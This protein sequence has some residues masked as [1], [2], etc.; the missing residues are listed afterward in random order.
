MKLAFENA[1]GNCF[2]LTDEILN[3][4]FKA[5]RESPRKR[6]ILPLHRTQDSPVQR[7]LNFF[8]PDT[9]VQPHVHPQPGQIETV[10]VLSGS[11][12]FVLFEADGK[13]RK[14]QQL[15][16]GGLGPIDIEPGVWHGMVCLT[17]DT[18]ILEIKK[19]PYDAATDKVFATWAPTENSS[20]APAYLRELEK[21][22]AE[23][24]TGS[25]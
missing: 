21:L 10:H 13:I 23:D 6:I 5:S 16:A 19:G 25:V 7:M 14:T 8:Q 1:S 3:Q 12:G 24:S 9:F 17:P 2:S 20:D 4:G 18:S 15:L 11:I 22:F